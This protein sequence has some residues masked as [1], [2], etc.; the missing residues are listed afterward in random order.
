MAIWLIF[1]I[2]YAYNLRP[3]VHVTCLGNYHAKKVKLSI[4]TN[5]PIFFISILNQNI[6]AQLCMHVKN[7]H[8]HTNYLNFHYAFF[9]FSW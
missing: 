7:H 2:H 9:F 1:Y 4:E 5:I 3:Q 8:H 6:D